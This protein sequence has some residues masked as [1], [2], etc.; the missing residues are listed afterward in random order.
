M[1][2]RLDVTISNARARGSAPE[3]NPTDS[4]P[5]MTNL[6][7]AI[8]HE[9]VEACCHAF[10]R[11]LSA[12]VL[13]GSVARDE[14]TC[15][16]EGQGIKVLGDA[17]F[18]LVFKAQAPLPSKA[19]L[20]PLTDQVK[21]RLGDQKI[22][23]NLE[24][25]PVHP[26]YFRRLRPAIFAYELR[27]SGRVVWGDSSVLSLIPP[28]SVADIPRD[29]AWRLLLNRM[30]ECLEVTP[31]L[32]TAE[33]SAIEKLQ[34]RLVKLCLD[35][36]TSFLLFAGNYRAT[37]QARDQALRQMA[38]RNQDTGRF[39]LPLLAF[40]R[41]V[42][43]CT[44]FKLRGRT[45][46]SLA[47]AGPVS[48]PDSVLWCDVLDYVNPL[49]R[50]ELTQL[51]GA[52]GTSAD[53]ELMERWISQQPLWSRLRGWLVVLRACGWHRSWRNWPRWIRLAC[54]ASPR[55][56]VYAAA[57]DLF[58]PLFPELVSR[59]PEWSGGDATRSTALTECLRSTLPCDQSLARR[60]PWTHRISTLPIAP[61]SPGQASLPEWAKLATG[62]ATNYHR[63]V[64][65]TR[66]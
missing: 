16:E 64:E 11:Q 36:A 33:K 4:T 12:I 13:T 65:H 47:A 6:R 51:L 2:L 7:A 30:I 41:Q 45:E 38:E 34:Y 32:L 27:T 66:S 24:F 59:L 50:W 3:T 49:W 15:I 58:F 14:A 54:R 48:Q 39:P 26:D 1:R 19:A 9:S 35:M 46:V 42:S 31:D 61:Q 10:G 57:S 5:T 20:D 21:V 56:W 60:Y 43:A 23:C 18:F 62:I 25:A 28:F 40:S 29:D 52:P 8:C 55:Y 44:E 17:E 63:F 53:N 22:W 37:Y